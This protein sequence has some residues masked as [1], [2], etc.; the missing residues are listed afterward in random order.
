MQNEALARRYATAVF[1]LAKEKGV[2]DKVGRDLSGAADAIRADADAGRFFVSPVIDRGEKAKVVA[3]VFEGRVDEIALH[4]LLL[5]VRKRREALLDAIVTEYDKLR[6]ANQGLEPLEIAS[7]RP[8]SDGELRDL[9]ERLSRVYGKKFA[10]TKRVDP[11]LLGGLRISMGD[12]SIDGSIAGRLD[13]LSRDL[14]SLRVWQPAA[15]VAND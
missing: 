8:L 9:V 4:T 5:L 7:A 10:V 11:A 12:R 2:I 15:D 3:A 6:L 13:A 14:E 1:S